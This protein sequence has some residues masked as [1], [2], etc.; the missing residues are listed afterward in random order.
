MLAVLAAAVLVPMVMV[1]MVMVAGAI[2][3]V[4]AASSASGA[5]V[6]A[7]SASAPAVE[8][9][10]AHSTAAPDPAGSDPT[11]SPGTLDV[12]AV[13][14][15]RAAFLTAAL[16]AYAA[17]VPAQFAVAVLDHRT[18]TS[19]TYGGDVAIRTASVVKV[20]ILAAV[21][22]RAQDAGRDL[23]ASEQS[24]AAAMIRSS[25]NDAAST[26]WWSIGGSTGLAAS[27]ARLGLT[28]TVP[29]SGE[30]WG[31]TTTTVADRIHLLDTI[32]DPAG[33]V[34]AYRDYILGLMGTVEVDQAWGVSAAAAGGDEV[35]LKNGWIG[36]DSGW[37]V[38][39]I[40]R[41]TGATSDITIAILSQ[42]QPSYADGIATVEHIATLA[43]SELAW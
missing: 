23:T 22:L 42:Y 2:T 5:T 18:G 21:V 29:G 3:A 24:L 43:R 34:A 31:A 15:D 10:A 1:P 8:P 7:V 40:G 33:P 35:A 28:G 14:P 11:L 41:I 32:A 25:D 39:S 38:N 17:T 37:T 12:R 30:Y 36:L 16:D 26:L 13:V 27:D 9:G 20:D 4:A 6:S 19:Y